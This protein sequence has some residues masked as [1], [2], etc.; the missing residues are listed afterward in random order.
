L[1]TINSHDIVLTSLNANMSID[2]A[3]AVFFNNIKCT[4]LIF[5]DDVVCLIYGHNAQSRKYYGVL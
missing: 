3:V 2:E 5:T 1:Q 4:I